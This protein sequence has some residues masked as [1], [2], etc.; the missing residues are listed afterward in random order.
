MTPSDQVAAQVAWMRAYIERTY[1]AEDE[2][3][4]WYVRGGQTGEDA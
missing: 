1:G 4:D 3:P 2:P